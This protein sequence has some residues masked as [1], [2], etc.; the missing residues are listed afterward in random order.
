MEDL[1]R[2]LSWML[3]SGGLALCSASAQAQS[4]DPSY[5]VCMKVYANAWGGGSEYNDCTFTS[6]AQC[7]ASASARSATCVVN[8][9]YAPVYDAA[10]ASSARRHRRTY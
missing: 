8:P 10:P 2:T 7:A 5:P 3:L 1:M 9:Y 6:M 4:Y